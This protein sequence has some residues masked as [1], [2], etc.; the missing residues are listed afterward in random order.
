MPAI[1]SNKLAKRTHAHSASL[2]VYVKSNFGVD[3]FHRSLPE[4][5][6]DKRCRSRVIEH[7]TIV[8]RQCQPEAA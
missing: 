4:Q 5:S 2:P 3:C 8:S 6:F 7:E 1:K